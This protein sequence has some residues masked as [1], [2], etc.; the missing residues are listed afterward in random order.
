MASERNTLVLAN[1]VVPAPPGPAERKRRFWLGVIG[2]FGFA[3]V[4]GGVVALVISLL[5]GCGVLRESHAMGIVVSA[6]LVVCLAALLTAAHGMDR[7]AAE[8]REAE[9]DEFAMIEAKRI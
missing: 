9:S 6:L 3:G 2:A 8:R 5:T 4:A 7:L 1:A